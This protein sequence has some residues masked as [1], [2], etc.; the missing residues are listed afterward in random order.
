MEPTQLPSAVVA[1]VV[2]ESPAPAPVQPPS[3]PAPVQP[4]AAGAGDNAVADLKLQLE[5]E[6]TARLQER[7]AAKVGWPVDLAADLKGANETEIEADAKKR[8][9]LLRPQIPGPVPGTSA[10]ASDQGF[11]ERLQRVVAGFAIRFPRI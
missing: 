2:V 1:P 7:V 11:Q 4:V 3:A 8:L 5:R 6:R 10:P 9:A